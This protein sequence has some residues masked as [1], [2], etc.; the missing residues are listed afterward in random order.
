MA[1]SGGKQ[2]GTVGRLRN[3][4]DMRR[5]RRAEKARVRDEVRHEWARSGEAA[6][7]QDRG[8]SGAGGTGAAA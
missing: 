5:Q 4:R 3:K 2:T 1:D 7:V 8:G 6:R